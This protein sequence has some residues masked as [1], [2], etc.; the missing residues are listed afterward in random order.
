M[1]IFETDVV[2]QL[3][4]ACWRAGRCYQQ[5]LH[6]VSEPPAPDTAFYQIWAV[7]MYHPQGIFFVLGRPGTVSHYL[8]VILLHPWVR[9]ALFSFS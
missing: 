9:S 3:L 4:T 8:F 6:D 7:Q 5:P 2:P 1:D